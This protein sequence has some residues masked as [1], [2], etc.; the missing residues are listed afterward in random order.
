MPTISLI[1][2][3]RATTIAGTKAT[4]NV[5]LQGFTVGQ[6]LDLAFVEKADGNQGSSRILGLGTGRAAAVVG[7]TPTP[8]FTM[9]P[10]PSPPAAPTTPK[11]K[12]PPPMVAF[13]F[14]PG[15]IGGNIGPESVYV[16]EI[17]GDNIDVNEGDW[18]EFCI[19][20]SSLNLES[21]AFPVA[22][23]RRQLDGRTDTYDWHGGNKVRFFNDGSTDQAGSGGA[24]KEILD[25][26][27][28]AQH[29]IF[30]ADWSFHPMVRPGHGATMADTIGNKLIA[31]AASQL[32]AIHTWD[33][34]NVGSPD[35]QNDNGNTV[36]DTM[37]PGG[38]KRPAKLLWRAS[39]HDQS[40]MSHHQKYVLVD[41][42]GAG[43][44][45]ELKAFFGGLDLT[46]GR[47]DWGGHPI[48][49]L[50]PACAAFR[51]ALTL[52]KESY[53]DWYNAE[54]GGALDMPRQ[55]WHDIHGMIQGPAAWDFVREFVGRWNVDPSWVDAMGDD[56]SDDIKAVL[57][58][59]KGLF[60][61]SKFLQQW[62]PHTGPWS[63]QVVRS[64]FRSH[65]GESEE[66]NTPARRGTQ[67]E[68]QWRVT[69]GFERSIQMAYRQAI[70][71][72]EKY[73]YI[74][75]QYLIG[76]GSHWGR[77]SVANTL[78]ERIVERIKQRI[79]DGLSFHAYVV[80][81]MFPEGVPTS[82]AAVSQRQFE[83][84]TMEYMARAVW[85]E[86]SPLGKDWRDYLSFGFLANW[87]TVGA[88][89]QQTT[90]TRMQRVRTNNRYMIYVHSKLMIVDDRY[91]LFG[92]ANLNERSL[93]G[94][95]D[96]EIGCAMWPSRGAE[97][98][99]QN[100]VK[101]FRQALW[102]EHFTGLPTGWENAESPTC[103]ASVRSM[104]ATNYTNFRQLTRSPADGHLCIWPYHV[105][106]S[107]FYVEPISTAPEGDTYL[108][109]GVF[110]EGSQGARN[111][112]LWE[113][114][115]WHALN[116][117]SLAE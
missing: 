28:Q 2:A 74:E 114:P 33:H 27:D 18:W 69:G 75:T 23:I 96:L 85:A 71:Q 56:G 9:I 39:S 106:A 82:A 99:C 113:S 90:G 20:C 91:V 89:A 31:K 62:E 115:G 80:M 37:S 88:K 35:T 109:D 58:M 100:Q 3:P 40:T 60:D 81:P 97:D 101:A 49:P 55:P 108:P 29:F 57:D 66:T 25:A 70:D 13:R 24:F 17:F 4:F 8:L 78:P 103:I 48:L 65:W 98:T 38:K 22:R 92:S 30:I 73:I 102:T 87:N 34:T 7:K 116:S 117:G 10:D 79:R 12:P 19:Q 84:K 50:D 77:A 53:N 64:M 21:P 15:V 45:R 67:R 47:F 59:F 14:P 94:D 46:Q 36:L 76:S 63:A 44:R 51:T 68:F 32:V 110:N 5:K 104:G 54:F 72:A 52:G 43:G 1:P 6:Q 86:A 105:D 61:A 16:F 95:R 93:A 107:A 41:C 112:W 83:W 26:I 42:P 11:G 111:E